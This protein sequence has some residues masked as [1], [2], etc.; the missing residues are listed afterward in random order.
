[1]WNLTIYLSIIKKQ[2]PQAEATPLLFLCRCSSFRADIPMLV[3][4]NSKKMKN[5]CPCSKP[6]QT[7]A[8]YTYNEATSIVTTNRCLTNKTKNYGSINYRTQRFSAVD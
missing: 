2:S 4:G 6:S 1:M 7:K 8:P 3:V 5:F